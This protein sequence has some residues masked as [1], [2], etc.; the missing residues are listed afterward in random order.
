VKF[1][2]F[3]ASL[4][5]RVRESARA[6]ILLFVGEPSRYHAFLLESLRAK[7]VLAGFGT[8]GLTTQGGNLL[9]LDGLG[10]VEVV[11]FLMMVQFL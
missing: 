3:F 8:V 11:R 9:R 6:N 2:S 7:L 4:K 1:S 5:G 10:K